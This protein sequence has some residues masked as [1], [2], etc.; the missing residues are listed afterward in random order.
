M[1]SRLWDLC[2]LSFTLNGVVLGSWMTVQKS[3][4]WSRYQHGEERFSLS[5]A[6]KRFEFKLKKRRRRRRRRSSLVH[7]YVFEINA[8]NIWNLL[9]FFKYRCFLKQ[10]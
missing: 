9:S 7:Q 10:I 6:K 5:F 1:T 8:S 3:T 2:S 4:L